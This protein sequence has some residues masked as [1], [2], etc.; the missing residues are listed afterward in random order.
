MFAMH[1]YNLDIVAPISG[2]CI[3]FLVGTS[4]SKSELC[5]SV[6]DENVVFQIERDSGVLLDSS[7]DDDYSS[8][9]DS[10]DYDSDDYDL[11][12]SLGFRDDGWNSASMKDLSTDVASPVTSV[13]PLQIKSNMLLKRKRSSAS[14]ESRMCDSAILL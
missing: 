8:D 14:Y 9:G 11:G 5:H 10:T 1:F 13:S 3:E 4:L 7:S 12:E 6:F 2:T